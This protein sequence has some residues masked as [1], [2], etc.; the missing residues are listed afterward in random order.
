MTDWG[1]KATRSL[2]ARRE[3][4]RAKILRDGPNE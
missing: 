3:E 2:T 1:A 4:E